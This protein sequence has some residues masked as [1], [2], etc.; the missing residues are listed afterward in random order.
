MNKK[1]EELQCLQTEISSLVVAMKFHYENVS[2]SVAQ[3]AAHCA[4]A[5]Y[6]EP[7]AKHPEFPSAS[8]AAIIDHGT[9]LAIHDTVIN[10]FTKEWRQLPECV[11]SLPIQSTAQS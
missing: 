3:L 8:Q 1:A 11:F 2:A 6:T 4:V 10:F 5:R 7:K 9:A